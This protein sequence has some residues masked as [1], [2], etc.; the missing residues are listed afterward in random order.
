MTGVPVSPSAEAALTCRLIFFGWLIHATRATISAMKDRKTGSAPSSKRAVAKTVAH[1]LAAIPAPS[2]PLFDALHAA[3]RSVMPSAATEVIS[4]GILGFRRQRVL[5]WIAAFTNHCSLF[6]TASV[7][8][9]FADELSGFTV[10]KGTVQFPLDRPLP[11]ALVKKLV[12]ARIANDDR[13]R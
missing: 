1:Y 6:P 4:Y 12:K 2:R 7:I 8:E 3:V 10:S 9:D 11:V 5:V 13:H